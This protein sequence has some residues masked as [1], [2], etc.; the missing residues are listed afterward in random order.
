METENFTFHHGPKIII[1]FLEKY[2]SVVLETDFTIT[3]FNVRFSSSQNLPGY[4]RLHLE[5]LVSVSLK[6][7]HLIYFVKAVWHQS[8]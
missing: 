4:R 3:V 6:A 1:D 8:V 7:S 2:D 5:P